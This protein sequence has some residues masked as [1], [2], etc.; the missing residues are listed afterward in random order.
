MTGEPRDRALLAM[1]RYFVLDM[2]CA[3]FTPERLFTLLRTIYIYQCAVQILVFVDYHTSQAPERRLQKASGALPRINCLGVSGDKPEP[4]C[5]SA[6]S[7]GQ[8]LED[9]QGA[10][11]GH[12]PVEIQFA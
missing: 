6:A 11:F 12:A 9:G 5:D 1:Q 4:G 7:G 8:G 3:N 2:I 10:N